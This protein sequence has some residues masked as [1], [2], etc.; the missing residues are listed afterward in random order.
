MQKR[1]TLWKYGNPAFDAWQMAGAAGDLVVRRNHA[2]ATGSS[3]CQGW[4]VWLDGRHLGAVG[5]RTL[6]ELASESREGLERIAL[7]ACCGQ[8]S[9]YLIDESPRPT[10]GGARS[11]AGRKPK[12]EDRR[13]DLSTSVDPRTLELIDRLRGERSRGEYLDRLVQSQAGG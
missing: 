3:R 11:G 1:R 9:E 7:A 8:H 6:A 13:V 10:W 4:D 12:G 2:P 5:V